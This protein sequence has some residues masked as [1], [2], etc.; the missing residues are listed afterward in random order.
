MARALRTDPSHQPT[1]DALDKLTVGGGDWERLATLY[2]E[3]AARP[4]SIPEHVEVRCRLGALYRD[5]QHDADKALRTFTR[6]LDLAP[7]NPIA[8]RAIDEILAGAGRHAEARRAPRCPAGASPRRTRRRGQRAP[9]RRHLRARA[10]RR[11]AAIDA[12]AAILERAGDSPPALAGL[13]RPAAGIER[14]KVAALLMPRYRDLGRAADLARIWMA[15]LIDSP[16]TQPLDEL[17][18]LARSAGQVDALAR[19]LATAIERT[20][21]PST[22]ASLRRARAARE[23][24]R[25]AAVAAEA[26][27]QRVLA[28]AP[29]HKEALRALDALL[30]AGEHHADRVEVLRRRAALEEPE[31]Q[32]EIYL[33]RAELQASA[34]GDGDGARDLGGGVGARRRSARLAR[35][36]ASRRTTKRRWRCGCACAPRSPTTTRR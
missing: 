16:E 4:L 32:R 21:A 17:T 22:R 8:D 35:A 10:R 18:A 25:G 34:L 9:A 19:T 2:K 23:R 28:E 20:A 33:V 36:G 15:A 27:L 12:Y 5:R 11:D 7:D 26:L 29:E 6:V 13:E 14:Q 30:A 1:F 3:I 24:E 31:A